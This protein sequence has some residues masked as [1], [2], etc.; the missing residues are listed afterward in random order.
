M[1]THGIENQTLLVVGGGREKNK[2]SALT[3]RKYRV[4]K[5]IL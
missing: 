3:W 5:I 4:V 2:D 1:T